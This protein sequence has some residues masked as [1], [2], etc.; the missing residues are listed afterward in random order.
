MDHGAPEGVEALHLEVH[1]VAQSLA[2]VGGSL[3]HRG[4]VGDI[5]E[6]HREAVGLGRDIQGRG[7]EGDPPQEWEDR[8]GALAEV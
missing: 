5:P 4:V 2:G 8:V 1:E 6:G 7:R 3:E